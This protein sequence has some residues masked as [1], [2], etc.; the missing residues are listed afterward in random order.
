L[1]KRTKKRILI[2]I[3]KERRDLLDLERTIREVFA[4]DGVSSLGDQMLIARAG[5]CDPALQRPLA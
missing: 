3:A 1:S 5:L 2:R 4:R